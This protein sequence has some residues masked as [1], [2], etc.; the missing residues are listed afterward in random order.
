M[1]TACTGA[2]MRTSEC[3]LVQQPL[4]VDPVARVLSGYRGYRIGRDGMMLMIDQEGHGKHS[5]MAVRARILDDE[6]FDAL[7]DLSVQWPG[8]PV[9]QVRGLA[10]ST[11]YFIPYTYLD[12][13]DH[14][15]HPIHLS[16]S[17]RYIDQ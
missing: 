1:R 6:V 7:A 5:Q 15:F 14:L 11:R 8:A 4:I 2:G 10:E 16:R 12:L 17:H 9:L 3:E 13:I